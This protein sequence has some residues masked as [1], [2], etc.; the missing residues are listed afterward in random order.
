MVVQEKGR[1]HS[2]RKFVLNQ[3]IDLYTGQIWKYLGALSTER[4]PN[5]LQML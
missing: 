1:L 4:D 3:R 2:M 5:K